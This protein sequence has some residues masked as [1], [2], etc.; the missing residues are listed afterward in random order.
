MWAVRQWREEVELRP[1]NNVHRMMLDSTWRKV[2]RYHG[3][4][5]NEL[6][7]PDHQALVD[8]RDAAKLKDILP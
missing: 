7:G 4:D 2:I 8:A 5:P 1:L 3:G 6:V